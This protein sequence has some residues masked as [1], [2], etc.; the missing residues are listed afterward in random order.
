MTTKRRTFS[1]E[2]KFEA[3]CLVLDEGYSMTEAARSLEVGETALRRWV[4]QLKVERGGATPSAKAMTADQQRI[5]ELEKQVKRLELEK[6]ILKK[7]TALLMSD[8]LPR[9]R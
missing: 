7:A 8:E 1:T 6:T 9:I 4:D 5:Q 2:F 3:A